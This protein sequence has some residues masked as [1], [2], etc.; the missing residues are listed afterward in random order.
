MCERQL[1]RSDILR[2]HL[3][4]DICIEDIGSE[5]M[6][7]NKGSTMSEELDARTSS[8]HQK[9]DIFGKYEDKDDGLC[10]GS[11]TDYVDEDDEDQIIL[12][13]RASL[14]LGICWLMELINAYKTLLMKLYKPKLRTIQT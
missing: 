9:E 2:L 13:K 10:D 11:D 1:A 7:E 6:S 12:E 5:T 8:R 14:N 3:S 4:S